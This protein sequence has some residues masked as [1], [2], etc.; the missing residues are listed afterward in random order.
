MDEA[1]AL[2]RV[3]LE[4]LVETHRDDVHRL[5]GAAVWVFDFAGIRLR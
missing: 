3:L 1:I 5:E 2:G 4:R